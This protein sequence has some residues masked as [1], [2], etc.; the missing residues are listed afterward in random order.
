MDRSRAP[1]IKKV[2]SFEI[3]EAKS[4]TLS[5]GIEISTIESGDIDICAIEVMVFTGGHLNRKAGLSSLTNSLRQEGTQSLNAKEI[6][7]KVDQKGAHLDFHHH[8]KYGGLTLYALN[9][10]LSAL[11]PLVADLTFHPRYP[12]KEVERELQIGRQ[13]LEVNLQKVEFIA[14]RAFGSILLGEEH[15]LAKRMDAAD[16]DEM[17]ASGLRAF[18]EDYY[19]PQNIKILV[20]GKDSEKASSLIEEYFG[21]H[22]P[23]RLSAECRS[24]PLPSSHQEKLHS[25]RKEDAVQNAIRLGKIMPSHDHEDYHDLKILNVILGGYFG[26]RLMQKIREEKGYTYGIGSSIGLREGFGLMSIGAEVK[27]SDANAAIADIKEEMNIL[28][29]ETV[30]TSELELVKAYVT[31]AL[32]A[33][34]DGPIELMQRHRQLI[35]HGLS[36]NF[37][38]EY[39]EKIRN[40]TPERINDLAS[41]YLDPDSFYVLNVGDV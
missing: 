3:P 5:N 14:N 10:H 23:S 29:T 36:V 4:R 20:S 30:S 12:E 25:I 22:K 1:V 19:G 33:G 35:T 6:A 18:H 40:C 16:F 17:Q 41:K 32:K 13:K 7:E 37:F 34:F 9:K 21:G 2:S 28:Q 24:I 15:P 38:K 27:A 26:S 8:Y 39:I 11:I 31:G